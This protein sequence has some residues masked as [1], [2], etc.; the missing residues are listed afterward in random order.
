MANTQRACLAA[1][2]S[3]AAILCVGAQPAVAA[4]E[5]TLIMSMGSLT[6][7]NATD[8]SIS[9]EIVTGAGWKY[10]RENWAI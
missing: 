7:E 9:K 3:L 6:Y 2:L 4:E 10:L 8:S 1:L 5:Q